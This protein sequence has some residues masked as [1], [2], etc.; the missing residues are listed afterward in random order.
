M[1]W[2][3]NVVKAGV[4][5]PVFITMQK[6]KFKDIQINKKFMEPLKAPI[7]KG[8]I[9]G[10]VEVNLPMELTISR[11]LWRWKKLRGRGFFSSLP[12]QIDLLFD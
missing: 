1:D 3:K 4:R 7:E 8:Q 9:I 2:E 11:I 6:G 12:D 5:A 10:K